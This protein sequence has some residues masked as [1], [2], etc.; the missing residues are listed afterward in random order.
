LFRI[1]VIT[2]PFKLGLKPWKGIWNYVQ[3]IENLC[4]RH[5]KGD[6]WYLQVIS[7][8]SRV[9]ILWKLPPKR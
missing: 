3:H 7:V 8:D 9:L 1:G 6:Y 2:C 5:L 4:Q